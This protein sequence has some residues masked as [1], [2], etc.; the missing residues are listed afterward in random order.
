MPTPLYR[1]GFASCVHIRYDDDFDNDPPCTLNPADFNQ[2]VWDYILAQHNDFK[3]NAMLFLGDQVYS[4]YAIKGDLHDKGGRRPKKWSPDRFHKLMDAMYRA[5][6]DKVTSFKTLLTA[7]KT[8]KTA[9]GAIWDDHDFGYNNGAGT[10]PDFQDKLNST[11]ALFDQYVDVL[12]MVPS[13]YPLRLS[14]Q[15]STPVGSVGVE[16]ILNPIRLGYD[17]EIV[18]LDG[19][20]YRARKASTGAE[21]LGAPQWQAL[22]NKLEAWPKDKLLIVCLGSTY[23]KSGT[24]GDQ[25][26][27]QNG[28]PYAYFDEFTNLAS[29]K[30][31]VFLSGDVHTNEFISHTG[32]C[33][34]IS[35]GAHAPDIGT[36][37]SKS[38]RYRFGLLDIY[39]DKVDVKLFA[40]NK[41]EKKS[42]T[43]NRKTGVPD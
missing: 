11:K 40:D 42:R 22:K 9:I 30:N 6:Y 41:I 21:L 34:V 26:W 39:A 1:V 35:S 27:Y 17:V 32:F 19:R 18:M 7:F 13:A 29:Q 25:S 28:S 38:N 31:I 23:S 37:Y 14:T 24:V 2:P 8:D 43:I 12:K 33:E 36:W 20:M 16:Q 3:L 10:D 5:Q 15:L 4:D